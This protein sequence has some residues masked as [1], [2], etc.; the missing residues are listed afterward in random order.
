M[1]QSR[2]KSLVA[3]SGTPKREYQRSLVTVACGLPR[4]CEEYAYI[5]NHDFSLVSHE[6]NTSILINTNSP[7]LVPR[8]YEEYEYIRNYDFSLVSR[9]Q[10]EPAHQRNTRILINTNSRHVATTL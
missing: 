3:R 8:L 2:V 5:R 10:Y 9:A 6:R 4:L 7:A 1:R